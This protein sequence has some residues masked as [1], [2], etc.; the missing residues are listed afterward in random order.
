MTAKRYAANMADLEP[1]ELHPVSVD[2]KALCL[3]RLLDGSVFAFDNLCTHEPTPLSDGYLDGDEVEC[4][5]HGS[6]FSVRDGSPQCEPAQVGIRCYALEIVDGQ[7]LVDDSPPSPPAAADQPTVDTPS[8]RLNKRLTD[9]DT[10]CSG[11][12]CCRCWCVRKQGNG[13][14]RPRS[15]GSVAV[16]GLS[17]EF[18]ATAVLGSQVATVAEGFEYDGVCGAWCGKAPGFCRAT[19]ASVTPT[20]PA[21]VRRAVP[22]FSSAPTP[23]ASPRHFPALRRL[24]ERTP[25]YRTLTSDVTSRLSGDRGRK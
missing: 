23:R 25:V 6:R 22:W 16:P 11:R 24:S 3:A 10:A 12:P 9:D 4:P 19:D 15:P 20:S 7:V 13:W 8:G 18:A 5:A 1:G 14:P 21:P 17:E 2:G